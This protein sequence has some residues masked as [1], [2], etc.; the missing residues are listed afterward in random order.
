[1]SDQFPTHFP[2][3]DAVICIFLSV[4]HKY[5]GLQF[6]SGFDVKKTTATGGSKLQYFY[7]IVNASSEYGV[8]VS[9]HRVNGSIGLHLPERVQ[10]TDQIST[11]LG[12]P[13]PGLGGSIFKLSM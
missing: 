6:P 5:G 13:S 11:P 1:M 12:N 7:Y 4:E 8:L 10:Y 9:D 3:S 2:L